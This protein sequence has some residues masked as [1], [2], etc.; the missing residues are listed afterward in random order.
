MSKGGG[1]QTV[2]S[3]IDPAYKDFAKENLTL[4]GTVANTP[5]VQYQ[6]DR[7]AGFSGG[8]QRAQ[9]FIND[10]D[11]GAGAAQGVLDNTISATGGHSNMGNYQNPYENQVVNQTINDM[12]RANTIAQNHLNATAAGAGAFGGSRHGI[13]NAEMDRNFLDR[14]G[15]AAGGLRQTGFTTA[16][17]LGMADSD[18]TLNADIADQQANLQA[19]SQL[20]ASQSAKANALSG[21]GA[22]EQAL[23]QANM[24]L[25]YSDFIDQVNAPIRQLSIRQAALGQ[26]PMGSVQRMPKQGPDIGGIM[27]GMG[28]LAM[29]AAMLCWVAREIYGEDN[30]KWVQFRTKFLN[31]APDELVANYIRH[32]EEL[33]EVV[34]VNP[35]LRAEIKADMD[36]F[37]EAA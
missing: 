9:S 28:S 12:G 29:G 19:A 32:G 2:S 18:R 11:F 26:T 33:A 17:Q 30:P 21:I 22:Q 15:A 27:S 16:A 35:E 3:D 24:D 25:A 23:N 37:M 6:G 10:S 20:M 34:K 13:A 36:A 8:Q 14:V 31:E 7:I 5:H 4:A 1:T